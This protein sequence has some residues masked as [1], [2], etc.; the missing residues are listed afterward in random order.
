M[1]SEPLNENE[2]RDRVKSNHQE[3]M[4]ELGFHIL[5]NVDSLVKVSTNGNSIFIEGVNRAGHLEFSQEHIRIDNVV[6]E[7][8]DWLDFTDKLVSFIH[9]VIYEENEARSQKIFNNL[10]SAD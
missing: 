8:F 4:S 9:A 10:E 1:S 2:I 6:S 7:D 3:F 5:E